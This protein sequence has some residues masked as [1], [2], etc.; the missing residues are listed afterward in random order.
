M[1]VASR[2]HCGLVRLQNEDSFYAPA[3]MPE[4]LLVVADGMG[5]HNA[6]E[7]ASALCVET[8]VD[9]VREFRHTDTPSMEVVRMAFMRANRKVF[10]TAQD[11]REQ[12]GMGTTLTLAFRTGEDAF[13]IGHV[14]DSRAY[15]IG[16][17]NVHRLTRDHSL[18]EELV[19]LGE[20]SPQDARVHPQRNII[21]RSI[22]AS[23][24]VRV[25][26]TQVR[27]GAHEGLMLCSDG[28]TLHL[29]EEDIAQ[30][31]RENEDPSEAA[32]ELLYRVL[33]RGAHDNVTLIIAM[34]DAEVNA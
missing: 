34:T 5:G 33:S 11:N 17:G 13:I 19:R 1:R 21:T 4:D 15:R 10:R 18:V 22:G 30:A 12:A 24:S 6:G 32:D 20:I 3:D 14:G 29:T 16:R 31:L 25:D 23:P 28:L 8:V 26:I 2:S 7:I 27:L 9:T